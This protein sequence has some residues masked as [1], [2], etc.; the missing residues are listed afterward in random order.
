MAARELSGKRVVVAGAGLAG[1]AAA[2]D[3]EAAGASVTVVE[4]RDRVG[5]RVH[6]L[7]EGFAAG[8]HA[9]AGADLV[10]GGQSFVQEL[11]ASVRQTTIRIL[12]EGF[13][14]YGPDRIGRRRFRSGPGV[15]GES[16][17][18]LRGDIADYVLAGK[19][20]DSAVAQKLARQSVA[21]W[22][23]RIGADQ[24]LVAGLRGLR[25]FF[26]ADPEDLA[27]I[28][29][30]DQLA[31][32][33]PGRGEIYRIKGGSDRLP[34]AVAAALREVP[35]LRTIVRRIS[36]GPA[37]VRVTVEERGAR[38]QIEGEFCV[39]ALPAS[40]LRDVEFDPA[41]PE[42]QARAIATLKYGDVTRMLLQFERPFWRKPGRPKAFGSDL[43]IGAVWDG[44]EEQRGRPGILSL[45]AGGRASRALREIIRSE[46]AQAVAGRLSWLGRPAALLTT[47]AVTWE[48][49]EW[50]RGGY[51][52]FDPSFD[53][54]LREWL[55]RPAGRVLFAGEHTSMRWQGYM[56][57]AI[58]TGKRAAAEVRALLND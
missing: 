6:T 40:T 28:A 26:L 42:D 31:S 56:N 10:E 7:R 18:L 27:L 19:R 14:Y 32:G 3:L 38:R 51:A 55:A 20:W 24:S 36:Q 35:L 50:S 15:F 57:G 23:T 12:R 39:V 46:G 54:R 48:D 5:G 34:H 45:L 58:E 9:E 30:V 44:A 13:G 16:A 4:A 2:R 47:R 11:A 1:L 33:T 29:L 21:A 22:T 25:G 41:L 37:G 17:R 49:D 52:V 43:P 8:Q 53:P